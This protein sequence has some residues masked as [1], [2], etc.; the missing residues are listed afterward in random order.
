MFRFD[1]RLQTAGRLTLGTVS[2]YAVLALL[3]MGSVLLSAAPVWAQEEEE[4][5]DLLVN[6]DFS[7]GITVIPKTPGFNIFN[8]Q[9]DQLGSLLVNDT[10]FDVFP[11]IDNDPPYQG[12]NISRATIEQVSITPGLSGIYQYDGVTP[13]FG[14]TSATNFRWTLADTL[15]GATPGALPSE[16]DDPYYLHQHF[17]FT[18]NAPGTY[19]F[20]FRVTNVVLTN[21]TQVAGT[22]PNYTITYSVAAAPEPTAGILLTVTGGVAMVGMVMRRRWAC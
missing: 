10:G 6:Y 17:N 13:V 8:R 22:S 7:S 1:V 15:A 19:Q 9:F 16:A 21:G 4:A 2:P 3:G 12:R 5:A 18:A 11:S 20:V 14:A